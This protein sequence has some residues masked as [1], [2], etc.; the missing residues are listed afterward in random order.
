MEK[1]KHIFQRACERKG[2][3]KVAML[4]TSAS[5]PDGLKVTF[6]PFG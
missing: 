5:S 3:E 2:G 4:V 1:F 6:W